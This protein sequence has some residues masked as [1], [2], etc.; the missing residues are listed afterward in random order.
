MKKI[1][2]AFISLA[3][4]LFYCNNTYATTTANYTVENNSNFEKIVLLIFSIIFLFSLP[5][6][7]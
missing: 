4:F 6:F 7:D 1:K 2:K 5:P 3:I